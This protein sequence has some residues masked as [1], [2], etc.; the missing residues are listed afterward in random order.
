MVCIIE[1]IKFITQSEER[2]GFRK[3]Y[4]RSRKNEV[5][6]GYIQYTCVCIFKIKNAYKK[7]KN[8]KNAYESKASIWLAHATYQTSDLYYLV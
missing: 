4:L 5:I 2:C 6:N 8:K 7:R 3:R 1:N